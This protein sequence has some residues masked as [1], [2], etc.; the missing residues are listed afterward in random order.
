MMLLGGVKRLDT[1]DRAIT[2][3]FA[4]VAIGRGL[5]RQPDLVKRMQAGQTAASPCIPC[6][7]C[8]VEMERGGTRCVMREESDA[9]AAPA[10]S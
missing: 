6:N 2:E 8:V 4:F 10:S 3:G 9:P 7:R 1:M 5:I